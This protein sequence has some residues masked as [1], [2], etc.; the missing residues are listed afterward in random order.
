MEISLRCARAARVVI[1]SS[2]FVA[3]TPFVLQAQLV[4]NTSLTSTERD[5]LYE[6]RKGDVVWHAKIQ[7]STY[8]KC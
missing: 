8:D 7:F 2:L 5:M 4:D 1:V 3:L 6:D